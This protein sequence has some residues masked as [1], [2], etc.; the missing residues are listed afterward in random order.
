MKKRILFIAPDDYNLYKLV[1]KNLEFLDFEVTTVLRDSVKFKYESIFQRLFNLYR[2]V[3]DG[4]SNYKLELK[5]AHVAENLAKRIDEYEKFD[6]CLVLRADYFHRDV[7]VK[8]KEKSN[9][10][11]AY[12]Y[13]GL[14]RNPSIYERIP[15]FDSFFV[16]DKDDVQADGKFKTYLSHNFYFDYY[17]V[18]QIDTSYDIYFLGYYAKSRE[19]L[20]L[21]FFE[22]AKGCLGRVRF[23]IRFQP[24]NLHHMPAY[25]QRGIECLTDLVPFEEYLERVEKAKVIVDFVISDHTGLSFRIFEGLKYRKKVITTNVNVVKYDFYTP[26]NFYVLRS[27]TLNEIELLKFVGTPYKPIDESIRLKYSFSYWI[28]HILNIK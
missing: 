20:L 25:G 4:N 14:K 24:E 10:M 1:Q 19:K 5:R 15:L 21:D 12:H 3:V 18:Q 7:L 11:V 16:F 26:D 17:N 8:A 27:D 22:M 2:K 13:D 28:K 9:Y 6:Y 23:E